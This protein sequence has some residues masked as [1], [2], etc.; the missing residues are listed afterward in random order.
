MGLATWR[1]SNLLA[2]EDGPG[3]IFARFRSFVGVPDTGEIVGL[4][5]KLLTCIFCLTVWVAPLMLVL[6]WIEPVIVVLIAATTI[7]LTVE[8]W[9][10]HG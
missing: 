3:D 10:D 4:A 7:A 9:M 8:R 2:N 6:W 1:L 5:P